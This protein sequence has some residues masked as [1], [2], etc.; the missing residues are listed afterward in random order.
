MP[1]LRIATKPI[2]EAS[3]VASV[4]QKAKITNAQN[5]VNSLKSTSRLHTEFHGPSNGARG[6]GERCHK[7]FVKYP[8]A[9]IRDWRLSE[10]VA[11]WG[12]WRGTAIYVKSVPLHQ[13]IAT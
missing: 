4:Y 8:Q 2:K 11:P 3:K 6:G 5:V 9:A 7:V 13:F 12:R 1:A 10:T